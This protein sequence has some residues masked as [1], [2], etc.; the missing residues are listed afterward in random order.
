MSEGG[1]AG[2]CL[3][4]AITIVVRRFAGAL[5][6]CHCQ[7]CRKQS[8]SA[9]VAAIPVALADFVLEDPDACARAYR[10]SPRKARHFCGRCGAPLYSQVDGAAL[11]RVRA[12]LFEDLPGVIHAGH[13]FAAARAPWDRIADDLPRHDGFEPGRAPDG[14]AP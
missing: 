4:G 13:I 7:Q 3:C 8:G 6:Y 5:T 11:V 2:R 1:L 12:G 10:A 14:S 9:F